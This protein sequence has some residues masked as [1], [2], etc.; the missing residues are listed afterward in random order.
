MSVLCED[1]SGKTIEELASISKELTEEK[2]NVSSE[3]NQAT[4]TVRLCDSRLRDIDKDLAIILKETKRRED[5]EESKNIIKKNITNIEGFTLLSED[6]LSIITKGMNK[7]DYRKH[8]YYPRF[9]DLERIC[10]E[11]I[12]VKKRYPQWSLTN[13]ANGGQYDSLPP[14]IF[15]KYEYKDEEGIHFNIGGISVSNN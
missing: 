6:E 12:A 4:K 14:T 10:K 15:Y 9:I 7:T 11:V 8:G 1:L 3:R 2:T 13:L 5:I